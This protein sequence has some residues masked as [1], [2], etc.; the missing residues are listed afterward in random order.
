ML[1][2]GYRSEEPYLQRVWEDAGK[3]GESVGGHHARFLAAA[4]CGEL[5]QAHERDLGF[6]LAMMPW[7]RAGHWPGGWEDATNRLKVF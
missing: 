3:V 1:D 5:A 4:M 7:V 2:A 6:F